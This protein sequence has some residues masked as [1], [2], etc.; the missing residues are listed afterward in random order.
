VDTTLGRLGHSLNAKTQSS[1]GRYCHQ[2]QPFRVVSPS[3]IVVSGS[4]LSVLRPRLT[5]A[6]ADAHCWTPRPGGRSTPFRSITAE[7]GF[8][9]QPGG[10]PPLRRT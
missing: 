6:P 1:Q 8:T 10:R 7:D 2:V 3:G 4:L 9:A 5:S